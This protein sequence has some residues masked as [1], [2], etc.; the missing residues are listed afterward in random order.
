MNINDFYAS[1]EYTQYAISLKI[2]QPNKEE[3]NQ[4][5]ASLQSCLTPIDYPS[6]IASIRHYCTFLSHRNPLIRS[7]AARNIVKLIPWALALAKSFFGFSPT[8]IKNAATELLGILRTIGDLLG[9]DLI[10]MSR[11]T[12]IEFN[13]ALREI[14]NVI[15]DLE[16]KEA[17]E[18]LRKLLIV[19]RNKSD[20]FISCI[21]INQIS[22]LKSRTV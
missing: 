16:E 13:K 7:L 2:Y 21:V 22:F 1:D 12:T 18:L 9:K 11:N 10:A 15:Y 17:F 14:V 3:D 6:C 5:I 8:A 4:I 20:Q 19:T